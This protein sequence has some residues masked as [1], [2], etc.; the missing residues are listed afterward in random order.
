MALMLSAVC[1]VSPK[2]EAATV[3]VWDGEA[4]SEPQQEN[5]IYQIGNGAEL[6]WFADY[7]NK[8]CSDKKENGEAGTV[9]VDAVLTHDIYLG[10]RNWTPIGE[11]S[12][13]TNAYGG[14]FDGQ[15]HTVFGLKID[16]TT[17][18]YGL[19]SKVNTGTVK[20]LRV[21]GDVRSGNVVG[22]IIGKLQTGTVENCS[23]E[24][25]VISDGKSTKGY[26]GGIVGTIASQDA[27][28]KGCCN[29]AAVSGSYAGGIIGYNKNRAQITNCYNTGTITGSTRSGGIAGQ[30]SSGLMSYCYSVGESKNGICGFSNAQITN[31]YY[32]AA[33][34]QD[35][36]SAPGGT[37]TGYKTITDAAV[38]LASLN[39]GAEKLFEKD[40]DDINGGYPVLAWQLSADV[41]SIPV[42]SAGILGDAV[43]G[44]TLIAQALGEGNKSATNARYQ[45]AVSEDNIT[46]TDIEGQTN[47]SFQIPDIHEYVGKYIRVS[48]AGE[49]GSSASAVSGP[50]A[51]SDSLI[52]EENSEKLQEAVDML[53]LGTSVVKEA[54][55]LEL[56][57][58]VK[59]CKVSW[60]SSHPDIIGEDGTI[61]LPGEGIVSVT[62]TA[63]VSCGAVNDSKQMKVDVWAAN[64]DADTYLEKVLESMKW[65]FKLL[66]PVFGRD[67]NIL[68]K[69]KDLLEA[70]GF[71]GVSVTIGSTAD[72]SLV[73]E[74]GKI[75]FP[76]IPDGGS[77]ADGRQVKVIFHLTVD[78]KTVEYPTSDN[79]AL[80]IPWDT[81]S[82]RTSL[83][84]SADAALTESVLCGDGCSFSAVNGDLTLPSCV[85]ERGTGAAVKYSFAWITWKSSD[86]SHISIS[87]Q[88]RQSGADSLYNPYVGKVQQDDR[89]HAVTLTATLK[90]PSTGMTVERMIEV[91][92]APLSEEQVEQTTQSMQKILNCYTPDKLLDAVTKEQLNTSSVHND[93][94]LVIPQNVVTKE[95]LAGLNYGKYWDYWNYKFTVTSSDTDVIDINSFRANVYRPLGEDSSADRKVILTVRMALKSN[96]NMFTE[97]EIEVTVKHLGRAEINRSLAL[98]DQAKTNYADGLLGG[99]ADRYSI[100][101][102]LTPYREIVWN[103]DESGVDFIYRHA[104]MKKSGIMVDELPGWEAQ[105]DWRLFRTSD[106]S[107]LSNETLILSETPEK[108]TFVKI[109]S[110]LTDEILGKY[111]VKFQDDKDYDKEALAK[112]RQ[113]YKQ[114]VSVCVVALGEG[115]YTEHFSVMKL[116]SKAL[117]FSAALSAYKQETEQPVS[118]SFTLLGVDGEAL[119]PKVQENSFTAGATVYDVFQKVLAD[120]D[121]PYQAKGSYISS[122]NGLAEYEYGDDSGWMYTVGDVFV[123]SY[124][125]AQELAGGEDIVVKYV[126]DY[127]SANSSWKETASP[128]PTGTPAAAPTDK[129]TTTPK[130]T[131][132]ASADKPTE[133]P[134]A[135]L[136]PTVT[137][138][139]DKPT[140]TPAAV[141][142]ETPTGMPKP[143]ETAPAAKPTEKPAATPKPTETAPAAKPTEKPAAT[144]KPTVTAPT[145]KPTEKPV[146]TPKPTVT[147]PA[148]KPTATPKPTE[149]VSADKP[150]E[151]PAGET[152]LPT[153]TSAPTGTP[154]ATVTVAPAETPKVAETV[155]DDNQ[156]AVSGSMGKESAGRVKRIKTL[157]LKKFKRGTKRIVGRTIKRSQL[158][159]WVGRRKYT[160]KSNGRGKFVVSVK[161]KLVRKQKIKI[162]V[163]KTGYKKKSKVFRVK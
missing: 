36:T 161:K 120:H 149:T 41:V 114:P 145:D 162:T 85:D 124:M 138:P 27:K 154:A 93:I 91:V 100:I 157:K 76:A 35:D 54:G 163:S 74:N 83:E 28:I 113:L 24:G 148:D 55:R 144:P 119:I 30:Q 102:D 147:T 71:D 110:V 90:N 126:K 34:T 37:A 77:M 127:K 140:K 101:D 86:E 105:E 10:S 121:I 5:G 14:T 153:V 31:C 111:Y 142:T 141:S 46:F 72:G 25:S 70:R 125:N 69:F 116:D 23:M 95:E 133:K 13:I 146:A 60:S 159:I 84:Q 29:K 43:T 82:V 52:Y 99:N 134:A 38:L 103:E 1:H 32:L 106:K 62:L 12:Y 7:V 58:E 96:P 158:I 109:N 17:A 18:D 151:K 94:Q 89:E 39:D 16:A 59:G 49:E 64:I 122:I 19:F 143:T 104:D 9:N 78:G 6:A 108:D 48:V 66:Q 115:S 50:I 112:F 20:N 3:E 123:N 97:K 81:G 135:T 80:L 139:A 8:L 47:L 88:N 137:A 51:K 129:P 4:L 136:K 68:I 33:N 107:L 79:Y 118:V 45:W 63:T 152:Q 67:T 57:T 21:E 155:L 42:V 15:N 150:T 73:S 40:K 98:M 26:A 53:S 156:P 75:Y 132:T 160:V 44:G 87:N 92:V 61:T 128:K 65:D 131:E 2:A 117:F 56:P 130:P 22:G 11:A